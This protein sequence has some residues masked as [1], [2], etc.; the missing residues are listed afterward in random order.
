MSRTYQS[1]VA[2]RQQNS[3]KLPVQSTRDKKDI[4]RE[5]STVAQLREEYF[6]LTFLVNK[7]L[8]NPDIT[9]SVITIDQ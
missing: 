6:L 7:L 4:D 2:R 9:S 3:P 8:L 1:R 5:A